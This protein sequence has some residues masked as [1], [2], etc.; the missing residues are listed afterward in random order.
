MKFRTRHLKTDP[1]GM[2]RVRY[3]DGQLSRDYY[4]S[5]WAKEHARRNNEY[6][7]REK[8]CRGY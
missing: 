4:N 5:T 3:P 7:A 8:H 1:E 2:F 6:L